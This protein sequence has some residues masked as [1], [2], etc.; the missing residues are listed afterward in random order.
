MEN[1][2]LNLENDAWFWRRVEPLCRDTAE[3]NR[4]RG[5]WNAGSAQL[6]SGQ[7]WEASPSCEAVELVWIYWR[8]IAGEQ[9]CTLTIDADGAVNLEGD[10]CRVSVHTDGNTYYDEE[11][12]RFDFPSPFEKAKLLELALEAALEAAS[13][14]A[15][16]HEAKAAAIAAYERRAREDGLIANA[17]SGWELWKKFH[18]DYT[19]MLSLVSE[20]DSLED[21][22]KGAALRCADIVFDPAHRHGYVSEFFV[23]ER[24]RRLADGDSVFGTPVVSVCEMC[25][26][27]KAGG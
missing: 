11:P 14:G 19:G 8:A 23:V 4:P 6:P 2:L 13:N 12:G 26:A 21:A 1:L 3:D 17:P 15:L 27:R 16:W 22:A 25:G 20:H 7:F 24:T 10:G 18:N 5:W 9:G